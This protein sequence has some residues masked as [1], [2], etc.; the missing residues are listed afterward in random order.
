MRPTLIA[1]LVIA[2]V[3]A[4]LGLFGFI[5]SDS[6]DPVM[7]EYGTLAGEWFAFL[8]GIGLVAVAA[9]LILKYVAFR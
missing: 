1:L 8:G 7:S 4:G 3:L 9:I 2:L 5:F 6:P